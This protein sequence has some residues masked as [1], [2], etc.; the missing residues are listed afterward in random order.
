MITIKS[1]ANIAFIKYWGQSDTQAVLPCNDSISMNLSAC[2]TTIQLEVHKDSTHKQLFIKN[3]KAA[4]FVEDTGA[5]FEKVVRMYER[6]RQFLGASKEFGFTVRSENSFPKKAGIASSASFFSGL[7]AAFSTAFGE[8]LDQKRLSILSRLSGSGS[9]CRSVPDGFAHWRK[10]TD[11]DSSYAEQLAPPDYWD[12]ADIV[13]IVNAEEK[14][15]GSEDGHKNAQTSGLFPSRLRELNDRIPDLLAAFKD[16]DFSWFGSIIEEETVSLHAV[17]MTQ[18]V[19]L[20]YWSG[21]TL[22]ILRSIAAMRQ[23]GTE[24]YCTIDAGE[25]VHVITRKN[26]VKA[27]VKHV[28]TNKLAKDTIVNYAAEGVRILS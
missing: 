15:T 22:N 11:S 4:D 21:G 2:Y 24:A 19:P 23:Q 28:Q 5:A 16:K 14:K 18:K 10:G 1:P 27:V 17:M 20:Y 26:D 3:Y 8:S 9:A 12:I 25:N 13:C 7:A 6:T